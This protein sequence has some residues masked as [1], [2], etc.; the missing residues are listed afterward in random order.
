MRPLRLPVALLV[1]A[2]C[3]SG[4]EVRAQEGAPLSLVDDD[5]EVRS[6]RFEAVGGSLT[7]DPAQLELQIA[8]TAPSFCEKAPTNCLGLAQDKPHPLDPIELQKDVVRLKRYY[9]SNGFPNAIV[10]YQV[11]LDSSRNT[12]RVTFEIAEGPPLL[13]ERVEFGKPATDPV[14]D[15]LAPELREGW[16]D[17]VERIALQDEGPGIPEEHL[18]RLFE[19][20]FTTKS[21]GTGLGLYVSHDIVK[22]HGGTMRA[23]SRGD[24][25]ARFEIDLPLDPSHGG[26]HE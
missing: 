11:V 16:A 21:T 5:T 17:F 26:N 13:I 1:L 19:P 24:G 10:D 18:N 25:G 2:C 23:R 6:L 3:A 7:L 20:F 4:A 9:E 14:A 15:R 22:R 8:T 12:T